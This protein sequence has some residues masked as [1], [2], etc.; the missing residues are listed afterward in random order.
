MLVYL[1][2]DTILHLPK[3]HLVTMVVVG[4]CQGS[5]TVPILT[6]SP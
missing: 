5:R 6:L 2:Q 3:D 4:V 1:F